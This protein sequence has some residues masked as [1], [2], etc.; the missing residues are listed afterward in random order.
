MSVPILTYDHYYKHDEITD[1][2]K[3]LVAEFPD[4]AELS[5]I[6]DSAENRPIWCLTL[7]NKKTGPAEQK[8]AIYVDG[9]IHAG[10]VT[11]SHVCLHTALHLLT[12]YAAGDQEVINLLDN[13]TWYILPRVNPDGGELYLN[14]PFMLRSVTK[15]NP[16]WEPKTPNALY[17]EDLD[18][19][20]IVRFMRVKDTCGVWKVSQKDA[21]LLIPR[22]PGDNDGDFYTLH[23]E[24]I[25][26]EF[27]GGQVT[28]APDRWY[29]D[30]NR[31][32]PSSWQPSQGR[33]GDFPLSEPET[34]A[35]VRFVQDHPNI[36]AM[37]AYHT[38]S[39]AILRPSATKADK[40]LPRQDVDTMKALGAIGERITTYP[41]VSIMEGF[42]GSA[43]NGIF[44]DWAYDHKGILGFTT[45]LWDPKQ[46]GG[47]DGKKNFTS[48]EFNEDYE[49]AKLKLNDEQMDGNGFLNWTAYE[50]PQFGAVE[51]G[52]WHPKYFAQ[53]PWFT[54]LEDECHKNYLFS[55]KHCA[56]LPEVVVEKAEITQLEGDIYQVTIDIANISWLPTQVTERAV[57]MKAVK[58]IRL[59]IEG[60]GLVLLTGKKREEIGHLEG[61][62]MARES[63]YT[64]GRAMSNRKQ[65]ARVT[66]TV[67]KGNGSITINILTDKAGSKKVTINPA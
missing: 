14:S 23:L 2:L 25:I 6:G 19:D 7:T 53:N 16:D 45:E 20:G 48:R 34:L 55:L 66:W 58:P 12:S 33:N 30:T 1:F 8:P 60:E 49:M 54:L 17:P 64:F 42:L 4:L 18:G 29:L 5:S 24:G 61:F 40:D 37:Q 39:G 52:G 65:R 32:F 43:A 59:E 47:V 41:C 28:A 11:A 44:V 57:Q 9:N 36:G 31:N 62:R 15:E 13:R 35:M 38:Q 50:H 46:R 56:A 22:E 3:A 10:E 67:K 26:H 21:R 27:S 63:W 51:I